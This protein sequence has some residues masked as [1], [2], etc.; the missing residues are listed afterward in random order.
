MK[1][2]IFDDNGVLNIINMYNKGLSLQ[3]IGDLYGCSKA[4]IKRVLTENNIETRDDSHK[5]RHFTLN[6]NYFDVIDTGNKA[7]CLGLLYADGYNCI[8]RDLV[9]I[10][11]QARDRDIL[12]KI[13]KELG[14]DRDLKYS[15]KSGVNSNWQDTYRLSIYNKHMS[16]MLARHGMVQA[17]SLILTFPQ[18]LDNKLIPMFILG[19]MDGDGYIAKDRNTVEIVGT[20]MFLDAIK[21]ICK[22]QLQINSIIKN[23]P[24]KESIT[25]VFRI[26]GYDQVKKFL[27]WLYKDADLYLE[28]KYNIYI[29]KYCSK[30]NINN[31]LTA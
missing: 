12:D 15:N 21:D 1:K 23:S 7:Y 20:R 26:T 25:K 8:D 18:W 2:I 5:T 10:E 14:S 30:E 28:R 17:K 6:E 27:D 24:K 11:L 3:K 31:T 9:K 4:V 13:N 29:S 19:F 16:Q 22:T